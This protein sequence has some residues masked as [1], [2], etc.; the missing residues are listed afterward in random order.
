MAGPI[1]EL[2]DSTK[3]NSYLPPAGRFVMGKDLS[4]DI[5][6]LNLLLGDRHIEIDSKPV[7]G[8]SGPHQLRRDL[9]AAPSREQHHAS[10]SHKFSNISLRL[11]DPWIVLSCR[12]L[13][14]Q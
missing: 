3:T 6:A 11:T 14:N 4:E 8:R 13:G 9:N 12:G 10:G 2:F 1:H 7:S 5:L